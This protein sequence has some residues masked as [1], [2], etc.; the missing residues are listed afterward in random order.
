MGTG[1]RVVEDAGE[2]L[3][4]GEDYFVVMLF[5]VIEPTVAMSKKI[6]VRRQHGNEVLLVVKEDSAHVSNQLRVFDFER[7]ADDRRE[8]RGAGGKRG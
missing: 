4:A 7:T 8:S 5:D 2:I 3:D 6:R 1:L